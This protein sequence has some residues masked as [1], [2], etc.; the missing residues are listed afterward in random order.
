MRQCGEE[1][2]VAD[3]HAVAPETERQ[4]PLRPPCTYKGNQR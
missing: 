4:M 3:A 1:K 2:L